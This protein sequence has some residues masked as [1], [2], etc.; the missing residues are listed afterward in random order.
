MRPLRLRWR[1]YLCDIGGVAE[2]DVS[3]HD[4][5]VS[6]CQDCR[7]DNISQEYL[8]FPLADD[9]ESKRN[10]G[11][12]VDYQTFFDAAEAV[13]ERMEHGS[14]VV[15][16]HKGRNRS[17]SVCAAVMASLTDDEDATQKFEH[18]ERL[19]PEA[20]PSPLMEGF[21]HQYVKDT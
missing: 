13:R 20:D 8:R 17:V 2:H 14:V 1:L 16:C 4:T 9:I 5:I 12:S 19:R 11:G 21:A 7:D 10:W 6:V 18:I 15:H 3:D